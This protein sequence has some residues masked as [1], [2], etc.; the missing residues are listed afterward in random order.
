MCL[1]CGMKSASV[2]AKLFCELY[3]S[4]PQKRSLKVVEIRKRFYLMI[5]RIISLFVCIF[6]RYF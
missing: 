6:V 4:P 5:D 1:K 3:I 2:K